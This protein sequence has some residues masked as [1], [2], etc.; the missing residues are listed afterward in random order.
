MRS[1]TWWRWEKLKRHISTKS[2]LHTISR[3]MCSYAACQEPTDIWSPICLCNAFSYTQIQIG[4]DSSDINSQWKMQFLC[5]HENDLHKF[6]LT[7]IHTNLAVPWELKKAKKKKFDKGLS[8]AIAFFTV[9]IFTIPGETHFPQLWPNTCAHGEK[10]HQYSDFWLSKI[11]NCFHG[12]QW[13]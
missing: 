10:P 8:K 1:I 6:I 7:G 4:S 9:L 2:L 5:F 12:K 3:M 13:N 11:F